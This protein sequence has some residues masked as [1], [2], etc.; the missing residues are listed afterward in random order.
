[1]RNL[2]IIL[3]ILLLAGV[4]AGCTKE[5]T[6]EI[7]SVSVLKD[8]EIKHRIVG[9]FE[10]NY[11][12]TQSLK[13]LAAGR[14]GEY[15]AENDADSVKLD[16]VEEKSGKIIINISYKSGQ[17]YMKFN[18]REFFAGTVAQAA[19][20]GYEFEHI[21]LISDAGEPVEPGAIENLEDRSVVI[22]ATK[23]DE[24]LMVNVDGKVLY[25]NQGTLSGVDV[26]FGGKKSVH[27]VNPANEES[28]E[29]VLSYIIY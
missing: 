21:A 1:M 13:E 5:D 18:H 28:E 19:E 8:G 15:C 24:E 20:E 17:D 9:S 11:Y 22:I 23:P 27:I 29:S 6:P 26:T 12:D 3:T 14:V 7:S 25:I 10:Q 4:L 2:K 16:S